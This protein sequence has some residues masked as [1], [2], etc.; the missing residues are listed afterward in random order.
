MSPEAVDLSKMWVL[1]PNGKYH[2][3]WDFFLG[4]VI[5]YSVIGIP[6][7]MA[8]EVRM[9]CVLMVSDYVETTLFALDFMQNFFTAVND[10]I[11]QRIITDY[12]EILKEYLKCWFWIDLASTLPISE[13]IEQKNYCNGDVDNGESGDDLK[14][15]RLVRILRLVRLA[16]LARV[17]KLGKLATHIEQW[18]ISPAVLNVAKLV[19]QI[20]FV[21]HLFS[22]IWHYLTL[23][24]VIG[25]DPAERTWV[26]E[27]EREFNF[28]MDGYE[29]ADDGVDPYDPDDAALYRSTL[30]ERYWASFYWTIA[31]MLAVGYGD[32][33]PNPNLN[34]NPNPNPNSDRYGDIHATNT[35]ERCYAILTMLC[36]GIMFGAVIAQVTR[37]IESRN[38][39]ARA[40]KMRMDE[41]KAY[42]TEKKLPLQIKKDAKDAYAYYYTRQS[43]LAETGIFEDLPSHLLFKLIHNIYHKEIHKINL[44]RTMDDSFVQFILMNT[45]PFQVTTDPNPITLTL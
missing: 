40:F 38:P 37:L 41:L 14:T 24:D 3:M 9:S 28:D 34:L 10:E 1:D 31:T 5:F 6:L 33:N 11:N 42:L 22:C 15:I 45:K 43:T 4:S 18:N 39:Q 26:R 19:L 44:F 17:L 36:G 23:P 29:G 12:G 25:S 30:G 16:K 21:A 13:I 2:V 35:V 27:F 8:F 32:I 20:F 7:R